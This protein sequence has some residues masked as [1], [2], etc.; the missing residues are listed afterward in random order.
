MNTLQKIRQYNIGAA[1]NHAH[2]ITRQIAKNHSLEH[3]ETCFN[4]YSK[5]TM[6]QL[7]EI[8]KNRQKPQ[9]ED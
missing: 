7:Q 2:A 9:K 8:S 6:K 1:E 5:I 4:G 3:S